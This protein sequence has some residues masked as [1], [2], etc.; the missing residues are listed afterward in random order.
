MPLR[1]KSSIS[2]SGLFGASIAVATSV[3]ITAYLGASFG[4]TY[5]MRV[6]IYGGLLLWVVTGAVA[7]FLMTCR[8]ESKF[9]AGHILLWFIS[10][11]LW[12][13]PLLMWKLRAKKS[14]E[15]TSSRT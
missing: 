4:D 6:A 10:T 1:K 8:A 5:N 14:A 7:V 13:I 11:W 12:P 2:L 3:P 9:T 15:E